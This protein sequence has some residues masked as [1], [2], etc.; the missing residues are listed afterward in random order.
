MNKVMKK[1]LLI[2]GFALVV[3]PAVQAMGPPQLLLDDAWKAIAY[4]T[5]VANDYYGRNNEGAARCFS[6][7]V[8]SH[9]SRLE[10]FGAT[11]VPERAV[12]VLRLPRR[13]G[14]WRL[15]PL[16]L[17]AVCGCPSLFEY[18]ADKCRNHVRDVD[19]LSRGAAVQVDLMGDVMEGEE[20]ICYEKPAILQA[21]RLRPGRL[22][23]AAVAG[24]NYHLARRLVTQGAQPKNDEHTG[25]LLR[26]VFDDRRSGGFGQM[27]ELARAMARRGLPLRGQAIDKLMHDVCICCGQSTALAFHEMTGSVGTSWQDD[28]EDELGGYPL[29]VCV[30]I[31]RGYL[32]LAKKMIKACCERKI[33]LTGETEGDEPLIHEAA[34]KGALGVVKALVCCGVDPDSKNDLNDTP[35]IWALYYGHKR[36][37]NYL[38]DKHNVKVVGVAHEEDCKTPLHHCVRHEHLNE[39]A[40][41]IVAHGAVLDACDARDMTPLHRAVK[42]SNVGAVALLLHAARQPGAVFEKDGPCWQLQQAGKMP[43]EICNAYVERCDDRDLS[44][45]DWAIGSHDESPQVGQV[46]CQAG[47]LLRLLLADLNLHPC[48]V[49]S[50]SQVAKGG[51]CVSAQEVLGVFYKRQCQRELALSL[52]KDDDDP[53]WGEHK[54]DREDDGDNDSGAEAP[55][56]KRP[57][58][59]A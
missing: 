37:A 8:V 28:D 49:A 41:K 21:D 50:A 58:L 6:E 31:K 13:A 24:K 15:T 17:V 45:I 25:R 48:V 32:K 29:T 44:A 57:R 9:M 59:D 47:E 46:C 3:A 1:I 54:R 51:H 40:G 16:E 33:K 26:R 30:T 19:L 56:A 22:V 18:I 39:L 42:S 2:L 20:R 14:G 43:D 23:Q 27:F 4:T 11:V 53:I 36:L 55:P 38:L 34:Q 52:L 35:L 5:R 10:P 12:R 7:D